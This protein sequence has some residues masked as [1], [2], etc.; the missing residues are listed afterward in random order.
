MMQVAIQMSDLF[1]DFVYVG[2][3]I[4]INFLIVFT[5]VANLL[6]Y[7]KRVTHISQI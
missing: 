4:L 5:F 3:C 1:N 7:R 6:A 2:G